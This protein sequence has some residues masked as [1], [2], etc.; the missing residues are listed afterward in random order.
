[1]KISLHTQEIVDEE[2][3]EDKIYN[4]INRF[5]ELEVI[6][7]ITQKNYVQSQQDFDRLRNE[8]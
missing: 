8:S 4:D 5:S 1:M 2:D 6:W 3:D 7:A